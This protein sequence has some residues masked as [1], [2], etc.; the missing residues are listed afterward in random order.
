M[1]IEAEQIRMANEMQKALLETDTFRMMTHSHSAQ[2]PVDDAITM[3]EEK[4]AMDQRVVN[5]TLEQNAEIKR[6]EELAKQEMAQLILRNKAEAKQE[7]IQEAKREAKQERTKEED[8]SFESEEKEKQAQ[9]NFFLIMMFGLIIL[10][11][12]NR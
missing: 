6:R 10:I 8:E 11:A 5:L 9:N 2:N 1:D 12:S 4:H 3:I 7:A